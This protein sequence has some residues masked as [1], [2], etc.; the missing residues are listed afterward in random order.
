MLCVFIEAV[1]QYRQA[2]LTTRLRGLSSGMK[3]LMR[4][5]SFNTHMPIQPT[6]AYKILP[7]YL[8]GISYLRGVWLMVI[9]FN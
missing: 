3:Y 5:S 4:L 1:E 7:L 9:S 2:V 6:Y 8:I